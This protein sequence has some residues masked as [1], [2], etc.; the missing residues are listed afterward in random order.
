[1]IRVTITGAD[2]RVDVE[3]MVK[4]AGTYP[5][6]EFG[7]LLSESR[8]TSKRYPSRGWVGSLR[9]H[10]E[11]PISA[12]LCGRFARE[13]ELGALLVEP[14]YRRVQINGY[15][16]GW[17]GLPFLAQR[18][19]M[20]VGCHRLILQARDESSLQD[21]ANDARVVGVT[22]DSVAPAVLFDPSGGRGMDPFKWP[23][24]PNGVHVGFAGGINIENVDGV[25][26]D[27]LKANPTIGDFW[28]D[29][30][31]GARDADDEFD[32]SRVVSVLRAVQEMNARMPVQ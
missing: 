17:P 19:A 30:E 24:A 14:Q 6:V 21:V 22:L 9:K 5:F 2:D 13:P 12:H 28:I 20:F 10:R 25:L 4:C 31:S 11:L 16:Q 3:D 32:W 18:W 8:T 27:I 7:I 1:M 29:M 26:A 15:T 23:V